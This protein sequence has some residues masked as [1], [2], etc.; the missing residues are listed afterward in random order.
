MSKSKK[1][2]EKAEVKKTEVGMP[3]DHI[4]FSQISMYDRCSRTYKLRYYDKIKS[5]ESDPLKFGKLMHKCIHQVNKFIVGLKSKSELDPEDVKKIYEAEFHKEKYDFDLYQRG[6]QNLLNYAEET[7]KSSAS[8]FKCEYEVGVDLTDETD[9]NKKIRL[10]GIIDR[11]DTV[12]GGLEIIDFKSGGMLPSKNEV[13]NNLQ[14]N[15]YAYLIAKRFPEHRIWTSIWALGAEHKTK[16][17]KDIGKLDAIEDYISG[18]WRKM[19]SDKTFEP[20]LNDKCAWCPCK[21][22]LY[23]KLMK[24]TFHAKT[25]DKIDEV[26]IALKKIKTNL[27]LLKKEK[28]ILEDRIKK[29]IDET[30]GMPL[31]VN[32]EQYSLINKHRRAYT[33]EEC[34]YQQLEC[35]KLY[36][37]E[38]D[39]NKR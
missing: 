20:K 33:C 6:W 37:T 32:D 30:M 26:V 15:I 16:V 2:V 39:K 31:I 24:E 29:V 25:F 38:L 27:S 14:L 4:S 8:I 11:I 3:K 28:D 7:F 21:C 12:P 35:K 18:L 36:K 10:M 13:D 9:A 23:E 19:S 22:E 5:V 1:S 17:E 34:E